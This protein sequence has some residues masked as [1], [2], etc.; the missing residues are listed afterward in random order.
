MYKR[1][2]TRNPVNSSP[3]GPS[4]TWTQAVRVSDVFG[5]GKLTFSVVNLFEYRTRK[6]VP[7]AKKDCKWTSDEWLFILGGRRPSRMGKYA[8]VALST[9]RME[10]SLLRFR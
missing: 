1:L 8:G 2:E 3:T 6:Q 9:K 10:S 4:C 5:L 7:S